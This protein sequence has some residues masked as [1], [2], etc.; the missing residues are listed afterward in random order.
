MKTIGRQEAEKP[1]FL[2]DA[3]RQGIDSGDAGEVDF[4]A[5]KKEARAPRRRVERASRERASFHPR[6]R[7]DLL[8]VWIYVARKNS[9]ALPESQRADKFSPPISPCR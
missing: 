4:V 8:E 2:R 3:W 1:R 5:L 9:E 7:K 6:A